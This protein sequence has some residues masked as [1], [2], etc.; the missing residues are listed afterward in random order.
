LA[1]SVPQCS[2]FRCDVP[3]S[4]VRPK[5][6]TG[7]NACSGAVMARCSAGR[8]CRRAAQQILRRHPEIRKFPRRL[9]N[10]LRQLPADEDV[11][12]TAN[13]Q[14]RIVLRQMWRIRRRLAQDRR[15]C[16]TQLSRNPCSTRPSSRPPQVKWAAALLN[17]AD[18]GRTPRS[19]RERRRRKPQPGRRWRGFRSSQNPGRAGSAACGLGGE[20]NCRYRAKRGRWRPEEAGP[21]EPL[22][23][24]KGP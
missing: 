7:F 21:G 13:R 4:F 14:L 19:F 10:P 3:N 6:L 12:I 22:D 23:I 16:S 2:A 9:E 20:T 11:A 24:G 17:K 15:G 1:Y 5:C 8:S 18:R